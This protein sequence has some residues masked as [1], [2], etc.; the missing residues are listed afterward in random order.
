MQDPKIS[1][2]RCG[3]D[4]PYPILHGGPAHTVVH[5]TCGTCTGGVSF[6]LHILDA[7][8]SIHTVIPL[9]IPESSEILFKTFTTNMRQQFGSAQATRFSDTVK[10]VQA[11][12]AAKHEEAERES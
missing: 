12:A 6:E 9:G 4:I 8:V 11:W 10:L 5:I 2:V 3:K 1:C 7:M